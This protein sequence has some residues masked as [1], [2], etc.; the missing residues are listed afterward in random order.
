LLRTA[1][2]MVE[3]LV[4]VA[5]FMLFSFPYFIMRGINLYE[6]RALHQ[7]KPLPGLGSG[8]QD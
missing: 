2:A 3:L 8:L 7:W 4:S 5:V 6:R 1:Q